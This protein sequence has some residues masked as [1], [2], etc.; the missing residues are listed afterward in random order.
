MHTT[1]AMHSKR[2][3]LNFVDR[4]G[5]VTA[6]P[7]LTEHDHHCQLEVLRNVFHDWFEAGRPLHA[8][9]ALICRNQLRRLPAHCDSGVHNSGN[10]YIWV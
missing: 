1:V 9:E 3:Q 8:G 5:S 6:W 10:S 7:W 2:P 4:Y